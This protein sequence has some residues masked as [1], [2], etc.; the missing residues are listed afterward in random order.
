M[1]DAV[2]A[3][4]ADGLRVGGLYQ[5]TTA[6]PSGR[7]RMDLIDIANH[8]AHEISQDLGAGSS[9][10]CL[11]PGALL[12]AS[13]VL[14]RD[15]TAGVDL[16]VVNKFAGMEVDGEG[17]APDAFEALAMGIPVLTCLSTR[18]RA[19]FDALTGGLAT[20]LPPDAAALRVWALGVL[21]GGAP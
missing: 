16:L 18:Y 3:L 6:Y 7:S 20:M 4:Q 21:R 17:L 1:A 11:N 14:R 12:D 5:R 19:Q 13:A 9:A 2:K 15:I 10:C 8:T